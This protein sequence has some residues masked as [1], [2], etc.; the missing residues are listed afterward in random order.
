MINLVS[1]RPGDAFEGEALVNLTS[2]NGQGLTTYV[3]G[4]LYD[5]FR[6][7]LTTGTHR[8][9]SRDL[10]GDGWIDLAESDRVTARPRLFW[11]G[12]SGARVYA[13]AGFMAEEWFGG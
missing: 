4:P 1:R 13:T 7:S 3:D 10:D 12:D 8:Q 6:A 2:R 5:A 9:G 11:T